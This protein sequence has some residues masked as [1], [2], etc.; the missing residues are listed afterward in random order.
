MAAA[1]SVVDSAEVVSA[2]KF[3]VACV[4]NEELARIIEI[5]KSGRVD[6]SSVSL[7]YCQCLLFVF[8]LALFLTCGCSKPEKSGETKVRASIETFGSPDDAGKALVQAA[9]SGDRNVMIRIFGPSTEELIYSGDAERD[10]D[11]L[12][13]FVSD[14]DTMHRWRKLENGSQLLLTGADNQPFPIPL[15]KNATGQ[16]F[17]DIDAGKKELLARRI[18]KNELAAIDVCAAIAAAQTEYYDQQYDGHKQFAQKLLS[19]AGK[20]NGLY[21]QPA[22]GQPKS[23]L[24]PSIAFATEET[25]KIRPDLHQ[26]FYG[27]YFRMLY[28]QGRNARGGA[29]GYIVNGNMT[30]GFAIAAY[31]AKYGDSGIMTFIVDQTGVIYQKDLGKTT[32]QLAAAMTEFNPDR[33]WEKVEL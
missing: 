21:W 1:V 28:K 3:T 5:P 23:P 29:K 20:Q 15:T 4:P 19:D 18:G 25:N 2:V 33:S 26:P 17:F 9:K 13:A 11:S 10:E 30:E 12:S 31:P 8:F 22:D 7:K 27:Y 32:D 24:G 14:F 16:W 6:M